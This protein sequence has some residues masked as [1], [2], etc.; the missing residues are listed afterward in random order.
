MPFPDG[1]AFFKCRASPE[2]NLRLLTAATRC[3]NTFPDCCKSKVTDS[4]PIEVIVRAARGVDRRDSDRAHGA[5]SLAQISLRWSMHSKRDWTRTVFRSV[6]PFDPNRFR[7]QRLR[8]QPHVQRH[9]YRPKT[10]HIRKHG[11]EFR[12][13]FVGPRSLIFRSNQ[14]AAFSYLLPY[15][16]EAGRSVEGRD[17]SA[18]IVCRAPA[19]GVDDKPSAIIEICLCKPPT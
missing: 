1:G 19:Y 12:Q 7:L 13:Q 16:G 5:T 4:A 3:R 17:E 6:L 10:R 18:N 15:W 8:R 14:G 9:R 2:R 11:R